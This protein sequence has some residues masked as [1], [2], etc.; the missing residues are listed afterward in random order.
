M[1]VYEKVVV[2]MVTYISSAAKFLAQH[3]ASAQVVSIPPSSH[4][5]EQTNIVPLEDI[6]LRLEK[7]HL[8]A[9]GA[10]GLG[11]GVVVIRLIITSKDTDETD[12]TMSDSLNDQQTEILANYQSLTG[13]EDMARS[14][15]VLKNS[16]WDLNRALS[17]STRGNSPV[18]SSSSSATNASVQRR[19][20]QPARLIYL[21]F[22]IAYRLFTAPFSIAGWMWRFGSGFVGSM[23]FGTGGNRAPEVDPATEAAR[24]TQL[25][26]SRF[27]PHHPAF[28]NGTYLQAVERARS[29]CKLLVIYL[30]C[31]LNDNASNFCRNTL[32]TEVIE[33]F[34]ND[35]FVSWASNIK[36]PQGYQ[37]NNLLSATAYPYIAVLVCNPVGELPS[38]NV[39]I[40]DRIEGMISTDDLMSRLYHSLEGYGTLLHNVRAE[41]ARRETDR[42]LRDEQDAAYQ[43]SLLED[44]EK[45]R[46]MREEQERAEREERERREREEKEERE[47]AEREQ[48]KSRAREI[49]RRNI[50]PESTEKEAVLL[51]V[52]LP[53]GKQVRRKFKTGDTIQ[54]VLDFVD[55]SQPE[56]EE[57]YDYAEDYVLVANF[58]RKVFTDPTATLRDAGLTIPSTLFVE[59]KS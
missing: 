52:K 12:D 58:P 46:K 22:T 48:V 47:R 59:L 35:N 36:Y 10:L 55:C 41:R 16:N 6:K 37:V 7:G 1:F 42:R 26:E 32:C 17:G 30:H 49:R 5:K 38:S 53:D 31:E 40:V 25:I 11:I 23:L 4:N 2:E 9:I 19:V 56:G 44:Q 3:V 21:P 13:E 28:L 54:T 8:F 18:P 34:I 14:I 24:F 45:E 50:P 33:S 15:Q 51:V 43:Q 20:P 57:I 39:G 27:G 29:E